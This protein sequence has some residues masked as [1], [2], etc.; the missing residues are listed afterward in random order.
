MTRLWTYLISPIE[1]D[2]K[3]K[4]GRRK[5]IKGRRRRGRVV[6]GEWGEEK[7]EEEGKG[8][9]SSPSSSPFEK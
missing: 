9:S 1:K 2:E 5:K 6:E 8:C 7:K 3:G 4:T